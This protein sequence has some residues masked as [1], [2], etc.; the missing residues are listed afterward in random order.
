MAQLAKAV[1][2]R[3]VGKPVL[4]EEIRVAEPRH[5]EVMV[6]MAACGVCHSDL[7]ATNGT[8][9]YPLPLILGHEGAGVIVEVG[10]GV[11]NYAVGDHVVSSFVSMC[12]HCHYCQTG[13][14]QLCMQSIKAL[15]TLPDGSVRTRDSKGLDLNVFCGCG[16]MA[17]Y[18]TM[19]MGNVVK[20]DDG[21]P[22]DR[23][24]LIACGVMT[25]VGAAV[26]TAKVEAGSIAVIFG[27]G[28]VGLNAIQGC[29]IAGA[30]MIVAVDTSNEKLEMAKQFGATHG[31]NVTAQATAGKDL[32]KLTGGGADYA[33][34]CVGAGKISEMAWGVLRRGGTAVIV[35]ISGPKDQIVLNAQQ[36]ATTEKTLKGSM[37]GSARPQLDFPRLI[38]LYRSGRLKLDELITRTYSIEDAPQAFADLDAGK[39]GRGVILFGSA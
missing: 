17:E 15:F 34:D 27:C 4:V 35:G 6:R 23:A 7:S 21:M 29:A 9:Q 39:Q 13:R 19:H 22:L 25:G 30:G 26:N 38:G 3:E 28:G 32:Y 31:Y 5:G 16:V 14:P 12:G 24:A 20:I 10:D 1:L 33:F 36:V 8:I 37:Y 18:A 11:D 2:A